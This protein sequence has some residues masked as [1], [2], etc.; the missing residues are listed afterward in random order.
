MSDTPA[1]LLKL[2]SLLQIP[3]EWPG[4][5]LAERLAVSPRTIRRDIERLRD[6]GYPVTASMG[7][8]GG[9]RLVAGTAMPPLLLDDEEAVA[10]AVGLRTATAQAVQGIEDASVRAM[11]KLEQVL[12]A[13]LRHRVAAVGA[14]TVPFGAAPGPGVD[15]EVL[16]A[17]AAAVTARE[18]VR[19]AY[20]SAQGDPSRRLAAPYRLVATGRRWYLIAYDDERDD[21]RI[22]RVDRIEDVHPTGMRAPTREPPEP[23]AAAFLKAKLYTSGPVYEADVTLHAPMDEIAPR[24]PGDVG[25]LTAVDEDSCRLRASADTLDYLAFSIGRLGCDFTVHGPPELAAHLRMLGDR[26]TRAGQTGGT[27]VK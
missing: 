16:S 7:A 6:L 25:V 3:R 9:Y 26:L 10:V 20:R 1:R 11:A 2:L 24:L 23:D 8:A 27:R 13:R 18:K 15:P 17:L 14:A 12:P 5:E 19:F 22:F 4:S 21:W